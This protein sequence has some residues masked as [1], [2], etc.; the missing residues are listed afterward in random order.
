[1]K[2]RR[3]GPLASRCHSLVL[4]C[5]SVRRVTSQRA[6]ALIMSDQVFIM[7]GGLVMFYILDIFSCPC[8]AF[9]LW[10]NHAIATGML[11]SHRHICKGERHLSKYWIWKEI[12]DSE[13][14][15]APLSEVLHFR[16]VFH[17]FLLLLGCFFCVCGVRSS[18]FFEKVP[19]SNCNDRKTK[20]GTS[21]LETF[22]LRIY[23]G[24]VTSLSSGSAGPWWLVQSPVG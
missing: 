4:D 19:Q 11:L 13:Q 21:V 5:K 8:G 7:H 1:M 9:D 15:H 17:H 16:Q 6:L 10:H 20:Q 23:A 2:I 3:K 18:L 12:P 14:W 24:V 22:L